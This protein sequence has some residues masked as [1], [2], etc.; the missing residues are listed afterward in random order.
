MIFNK[1]WWLLLGRVVSLSGGRVK[2]VS[3]GGED[4]GGKREGVGGGE[5][6]CRGLVKE[7]GTV[8]L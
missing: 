5:V 4:G 7:S 6:R 2:G 8:L 3:G 1:W